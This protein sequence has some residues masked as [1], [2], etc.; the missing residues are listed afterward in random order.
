MYDNQGRLVD[1]RNYYSSFYGYKLHYSDSL[2]TKEILNRDE[3]P[4]KEFYYL[5]AQ[6]R[7]VKKVHIGGVYGIYE[8]YIYSKFD[9]YGNWTEL[10][11]RSYRHDAYQVMVDE[12][13]GLWFAGK[14][15]RTS[16]TIR[17]I[18]YFH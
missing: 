11:K 12:D 14:E 17:Q 10:L 7:V 1:Y 15:K 5:D 13:R 18:E 4:E 9:Q 2:V 3:V 16:R 8:E 6:G